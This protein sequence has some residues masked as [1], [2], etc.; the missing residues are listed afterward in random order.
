[1]KNNSRKI[2]LVMGWTLMLTPIAV[3]LGI[4]IHKVGWVNA[5]KLAGSL[6]GILFLLYVFLIGLAIVKDYFDDNQG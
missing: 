1:M 2:E 4:L 5:L 6:V 3:A